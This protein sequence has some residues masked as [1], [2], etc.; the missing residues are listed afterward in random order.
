MGIKGTEKPITLWGYLKMTIR[1]SLAQTRDHVKMC[2]LPIRNNSPKP[3]TEAVLGQG[4]V[5]VFTI[6]FPLHNTVPQLPKGS[7]TKKL[8][9][10]NWSQL[11]IIKYFR[12]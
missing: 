3:K 2:T 6:Y 11:V 9:I 1:S 10:L 5:N 12:T 4:S 7:Q 8:E